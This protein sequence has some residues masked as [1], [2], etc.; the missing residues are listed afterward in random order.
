MKEYGFFEKFQEKNVY[1]SKNPSN[2]PV[3]NEIFLKITMFYN[4]I[5]QLMNHL[6]KVINIIFFINPF[7]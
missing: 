4:L 3:Q 1:L 2:S 7:F 5:R 6:Q